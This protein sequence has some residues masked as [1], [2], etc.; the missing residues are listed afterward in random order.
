M[1]QD[2]MEGDLMFFSH[3]ELA[4]R[5]LIAEWE[6]RLM[7]MQCGVEIWA[8]V[9]MYVCKMSCYLAP[10]INYAYETLGQCTTCVTDM[11]RHRQNATEELRD[12]R[13]QDDR[14]K[15]MV[16]CMSLPVSGG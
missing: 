11:E 1:Q 6:A 2:E 8:N 10:R 13:R 16:V 7:I 4:H 14:E 12:R 15:R 9:C 5:V 3:A